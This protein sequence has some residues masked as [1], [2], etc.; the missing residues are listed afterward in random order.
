MSAVGGS[1]A[2]RIGNA[3]DDRLLY[4]IF[5][6]IRNAAAT[7]FKASRGFLE[8]YVTLWHR[9]TVHEI[10]NGFRK[11]GMHMTI[12]LTSVTNS[13]VYQ[14]SDRRLTSFDLRRCIVDSEANKRMLV[15]GYR[16]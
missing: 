8:S 10:G 6:N 2:I 12:I 13:G 14:V 1:P 16:A 4:A 7:S 15:N 3:W 9:T 11:L 5:I